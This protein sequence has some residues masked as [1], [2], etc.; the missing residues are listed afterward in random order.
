MF[1]LPPWVK[2]VSQKDIG[3][4]VHPNPI[5]KMGKSPSNQLHKCETKRLKK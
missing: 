5:P 3:S 4:F 1:E 2:L